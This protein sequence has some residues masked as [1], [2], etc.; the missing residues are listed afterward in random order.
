MHCVQEHTHVCAYMEARRGH[1][2][3]CYIPLGLISKMGSLIESGASLSANKS[4][5]SSCFC[6]PKHQD[7][8][9]T[10]PHLN[11]Y[12][13]AGNLNSSPHGSAALLPTESFLQP[14][15]IHVVVLYLIPLFIHGSECQEPTMSDLQKVTWGPSEQKPRN[16]SHQFITGFENVEI[17]VSLRFLFTIAGQTSRD[18]TRGGLPQS[19]VYLESHCGHWRE[20]TTLGM[21]LV[22]S[23]RRTAA[24]S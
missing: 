7:C 6:L 5:C 24:Q 17:P 12:I 1:W 2:V 16:T 10:W 19:S 13:G 18:S 15:K 9:H 22:S 3:P 20:E 4:P 11:A 14:H 23:M 8:K 21:G